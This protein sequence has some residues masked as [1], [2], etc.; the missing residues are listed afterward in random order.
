[1]HLVLLFQK[2]PIAT[3][4]LVLTFLVCEL[5]PVPKINLNSCSGLSNVTGTKALV[6]FFP[7]LASKFCC[8]LSNLCNSIFTL[9][10]FACLAVKEE[11][12]KR[13]I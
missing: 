5:C 6:I 9:S 13:I 11:N 12:L 2:R 8:I 4:K 10:F 3:I 1:M 7:F